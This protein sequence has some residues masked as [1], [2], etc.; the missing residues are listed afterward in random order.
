M[1][2]IIMLLKLKRNQLWKIQKMFEKHI[3]PEVVF[4]VWNLLLKN[5]KKTEL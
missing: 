1:F 5:I 2:G 4:G 3:L